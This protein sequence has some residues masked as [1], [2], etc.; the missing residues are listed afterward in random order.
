MQYAHRTRSTLAGLLTIVLALA[1]CGGGG[2]GGGGGP[3]FAYTTPAPTYS[4]CTA[5]AANAPDL[6]TLVAT[7]FSVTPTLPTGLSLDTATGI[8][9]GTPEVALA[10]TTF[11]VTADTTLGGASATVVITVS[12]VTPSFGYGGTVTPARGVAFSALPTVSTGAIESYA[13][14]SGTLPDG[15]TLDLVTGELSGTTPF[16]VNEVVTITGTD[17]LGDTADLDVTIDVQEPR[18]RGAWIANGSDGT[19]TSYVRRASDGQFVATGYEPS[20]AGSNLHLAAHPSGRFLYATSNATHEIEVYSADLDDGR[21][22]ATGD[23]VDLGAV[24]ITAIACEPRGESVY[25]TT[26]DGLV[27]QFSIDDATGALTALTPA[28]VATDAGPRAILVHPAGDFVYVACQTAQSVAVYSRDALTGGL[29]AG[30]SASTGIG[31]F[32]LAIQPDGSVLYAAG[33]TSTSIVGFDVNS[34]TGA[35]TAATWSPFTLAHTGTLS[36]ALALDGSA[37]YAANALNAVVD[38]LDVDTITG[39]PSAMTPA[40]VDVPSTA[41]QVK[42]D[43]RSATAYVVLVDSSIASFDIDGATAELTPSVDPLLVGRFGARELEFQPTDADPTLDTVAFYALD[44]TGTQVAAYGFDATTGA[45]DDVGTIDTGD[46]DCWAVIAHP[47]L[48]RLYVSNDNTPASEG[49]VVALSIG[50]DQSLSAFGAYGTDTSLDGM[51]LGARGRFLFQS[52][53][54]LQSVRVYIVDP[55]TG[56]LTLGTTVATG[57]NP[58]AL[59]VHPAGRLLVVPNN[60]SDSVDLFSIDPVTGALTLEQNQGT[61]SSA[62][63]QV[64]FHPSG[65]FFYVVTLATG[66]VEA[67]ALNVGTPSFSAIGTPANDLD[68]PSYA[69]VSPDGRHL[70]AVDANSETLGVWDVDLDPANLATDGVLTLVGTTTITGLTLLRTVQFDESGDWLFLTDSSG[71]IQVRPFDGTNGTVGSPAATATPGGFLRQIATRQSIR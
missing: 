45:L 23:S 4:A 1:S 25:A 22:T 20:A 54:D 27:H 61:A 10:A 24:T 60:G 57:V 55:S 71:G 40:T 17:C 9:S 52:R 16:R 19:L 3:S 31:T 30:A 51:T 36:L 59:A 44:T 46:N 65:R 7:T 18:A 5:I 33:P 29:T 15:V 32:A 35:L 47:R 69:T 48:P 12:A 67:F 26:N 64:V 53:W 2:G 8:I 70:V 21:L 28:T 66:Q 50:T 68:L 63:F 37:L 42:V 56:A 6:G 58:G 38:Q 34:G 14:T 13:V 41:L 11:T 39:A 62:P 49:A 43:P